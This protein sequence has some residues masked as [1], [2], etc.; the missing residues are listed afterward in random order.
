VTGKPKRG[1]ELPEGKTSRRRLGAIFGGSTFVLLIL[2]YLVFNGMVYGQVGVSEVGGF[3]LQIDEVSG[4]GLYIYPGAGD[5]SNCPDTRP[6]NPPDP[7]PKLGEDVLPQ[8]Y[9]DVLN[10]NV[11]DNSDISFSKDIAVPDAVPGIAGFRI[12]LTRDTPNVT[13]SLTLGDVQVGLTDV[14]AD[15]ISL[16]G[17]TTDLVIDD[18][19]RGDTGGS[20]PSQSVP[21]DQIFGDPNRGDFFND[22]GGVLTVEGAVGGSI[23]VQNANANAHYLSFGALNDFRKFQLDVEYID[24]RA[25]LDIASGTCPVV[26]SALFVF[27]DNINDPVQPGDQ[28]QVDVTVQNPGADAVDGTVELFFDGNSFDSQFVD[29]TSSESPGTKTITLTGNVDSNKNLGFYDA[30]V[31]SPDDDATR[32]VAVGQPPDVSVTITG[33]NSPQVEGSDLNVTADLTNN[34]QITANQNVDLNILNTQGTETFSEVDSIPVTIDRGNTVTKT[35]TWNTQDGEAGNY[36]AEV[37]SDQD[38]DTQDITVQSDEAFF[39]VTIDSTNEPVVEGDTLSVDATVDNLGAVQGTQYVTLTRANATAG[40]QEVVANKSVTVAGGSSKTV[41]LPWYTETGDADNSTYSVT[42]ASDDDSAQVSGQDVVEPILLTDITGTNQ[43]VDEGDQLN[44]DVKITNNAGPNSVESVSG[45]SIL[46]IDID[47]D[48]TLEV[49][50]DSQQV[51]VP[52]GSSETITLSYDTQKGDSPTID[53]FVPT[54]KDNTSQFTSDNR[55]VDINEPIIS[56]DGV[57][58]DGDEPDDNDALQIGD[59]GGGEVDVEDF[60]IDGF[61]ATVTGIDG[62]TNFQRNVTLRFSNDDDNTGDFVTSTFTLPSGITA[63]GTSQFVGTGGNLEDTYVLG[64]SGT[65]EQASI[66]VSNTPKVY[67]VLEGYNGGS[68]G[69]GGITTERPEFAY[70]GNG[71]SASNGDIFG[72]GSSTTLSGTVVNNGKVTDTQDM[73]IY[74]PPGPSSGSAADDNGFTPREQ[75]GSSGN[76]NNFIEGSS[77]GDDFSIG[78]GTDTL[79]LSPSG[80][81]TVDGTYTASCSHFADVDS[82]NN[83]M[84][85]GIK[86]VGTNVP[87]SDGKELDVFIVDAGTTGYTLDPCR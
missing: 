21:G 62:S 76:G 10:A 55:T 43:P 11:P 36:Q 44:V 71:I 82:D 20:Y 83:N 59:A 78:G 41:T 49:N 63:D 40:V 1:D 4:D 31:Q 67:F 54:I 23:S 70:D 52:P 64:S 38:T 85:V 81:G 25:N 73:E 17:G 33:T 22:P 50:A 34:G 60:N 29:F 86:T 77:T 61:S 7:D 56:I 35:F 46:Y 14:T 42:V 47:G 13:Q 28:L 16:S 66:T 53:A 79:T 8:V 75:T 58:P 30:T 2:L 37:E 3:N 57:T 45:E 80:T 65:G 12:S 5:S 51:T 74:L 87:S 15:E 39:D 84:D 69:N 48:D 68:A 27:I 26:G 9:L 72:D 6:G 32:Q 19:F 18:D 24:D